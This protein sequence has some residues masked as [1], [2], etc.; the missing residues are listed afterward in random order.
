[1][2]CCDEPKSYS[3]VFTLYF[4]PHRAGHRIGKICFD[5]AEADGVATVVLCEGHGTATISGAIKPSD[6]SGRVG[7]VDV[8][9]ADMPV[10]AACADG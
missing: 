2:T 3:S 5:C 10:A 7:C 1:M 4:F 8:G 9:E 6:S